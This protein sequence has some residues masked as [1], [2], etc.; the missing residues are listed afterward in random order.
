MSS[1]EI[2]ILQFTFSVLVISLIARWHVAPWLAKMP[3]QTALSIL[4]LPHAFRHIGMTFLTPVV[5][6]EAMP[7]S[8]AMMAGYGD[9]AS[10]V[11]AVLALAALRL[12]GTAALA[13]VWVFNLVGTADL[14]NAL[15]HAEAIPHFGATWFI[16]TFLVPLLLVT[17]VM[18]FARLLRPD[19]GARQPN[20]SADKVPGR[21]P[22][23]Q[24]QPSR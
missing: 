5:V 3:M 20:S 19:P 10:A 12:S 24:S 13:V 17:H 14:L 6:S 16:P 9:L 2:F 23:G 8:F 7:R 4:I 22:S 15:R 1:L 11:L 18:V 21:H